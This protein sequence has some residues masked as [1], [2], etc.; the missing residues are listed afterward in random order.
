[1]GVIVSQYKDP[2]KPI[3]I[4]DFLEACKLLVPEDISSSGMCEK[5]AVN[6]WA[7]RTS[8]P[9]KGNTLPETNIFAPENGWLED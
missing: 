3:S 8:P 4:I 1:M 7:T 6:S 9:L 5:I 2:Y